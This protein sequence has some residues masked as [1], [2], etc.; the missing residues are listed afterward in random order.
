MKYDIKPKAQV[1]LPQIMSRE[2]C[3]LIKKKII[4]RAL[5]L[6]INY[7]SYKIRSSSYELYIF[8]LNFYVIKKYEKNHLDSKYFSPVEMFVESTTNILK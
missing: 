4:L 6:G 3:V 8:V 7:A 1:T 5:S 2:L